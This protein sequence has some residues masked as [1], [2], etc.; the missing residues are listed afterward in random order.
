MHSPFLFDFYT[1]TVKYKAD[2][3][4]PT[5]ED[6]RRQ[7]LKNPTCV[8][9]GKLGTHLVPKQLKVKDIASSSLSTTEQA[10][11]LGGLSKYLRPN[12]I[13]ELGTSFGISASY[14][15]T[16]APNAS[17][18]T[19][20]GNAQ[21]AAI[22]QETLNKTAAHAKVVI[23]T[24]EEQLEKV[25]KHEKLVDLVFVDGNHTHEAALRYYK[26]CKQYSHEHTVLV[27][28]DIYWSNGMSC[29][30]KELVA[31][32]ENVLTVDLFHFGLVFFRSN[33][34]KQHFVLK[35]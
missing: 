27:F 30:W 3:I 5:I 7:L 26:L 23:G 24:F 1:K 25:L 20:E 29:A 32:K 33:Q 14:L 2:F 22:A 19:I 9:L 16:Y 6:V 11:F 28:H 4:L 8:T 10:A 13:V 21:I 18:T 35:F 15:A 17:F 31:M 12:T 34:P